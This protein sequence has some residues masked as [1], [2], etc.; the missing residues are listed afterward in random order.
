MK[1][2][3]AIDEKLELKGK[4]EKRI[5]QVSQNYIEFI[6]KQGDQFTEFKKYVG[7]ELEVHDCNR[8]GLEKIVKGLNNKVDGL[9]ET[10]AI[11]RQHFKNIDRLQVEEVLK[12]KDQLLAQ[13]SRDMAV[14]VEVLVSQ[15]YAKSARKQ[16]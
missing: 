6:R 13:M 12:Q 1:V 9:K 8:E 5:E 15:M 3:V 4:F 16:A 7:I 11:P 14:P 2:Q 10:L